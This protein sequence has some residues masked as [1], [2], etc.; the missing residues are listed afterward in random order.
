MPD[1]DHLK[2]ASLTQK[3]ADGLDPLG[4]K[5]SLQQAGHA[6]LDFQSYMTDE[7]KK[8]RWIH[9]AH[10]FSNSFLGEIAQ[11]PHMLGGF[12]SSEDLIST[13]VMLLSAGHLTTNHSLSSSLASL[14]SCPSLR[15]LITT[16]DSPITAVAI[17]EFF[18]YHS[19]AQITRRILID[20]VTIAGHRLLKGQALWLALVSA[21]RDESVFANPQTLNL[22]RRP[23]PHL[24]FGAGEH[25]CLGTHLARIQ[26]KVFLNTL[27]GRFPTLRIIE[28]T[29]DNNLV[30]RGIKRLLLTI[31]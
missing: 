23:N 28:N 7:L 9:H 30:F 17:E 4:P 15:S 1:Q 26:L 29:P 14:L 31:H 13:T 27:Q 3:V 10:E 11:C 12:K 22:S 5:H 16:E 25:F 20:D 18:R 21:N 19:P 2:L 24:A 6:Y 8:G